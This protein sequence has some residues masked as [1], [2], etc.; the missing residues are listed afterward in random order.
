MVR[1]KWV[2]HTGRSSKINLAQSHS[3]ERGLIQISSECKVSI[4]NLKKSV[5][6]CMGRCRL[7]NTTPEI[8]S[9]ICTSKQKFDCVQFPN[10]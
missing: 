6:G 3:A 1:L 7:E 4:T 5:K 10:K 8:Q 2:G 9:L